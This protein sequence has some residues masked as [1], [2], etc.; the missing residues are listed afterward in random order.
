MVKSP[1]PDRA[2]VVSEAWPSSMAPAV[3]I[4]LSSLMVRAVANEFS[5]LPEPP[6]F[7]TWK[8]IAPPAPD[9]LP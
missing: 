9:P 8:R 6:S 2:N 1:E 3:V 4:V 7:A 5:E